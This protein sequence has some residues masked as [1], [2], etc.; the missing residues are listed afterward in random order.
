MAN[1]K[2]GAAR[3]LPIVEDASWDGDAA[4]AGIFRLDEAQWRRGFLFY[5]ADAP[6]N[7]T[8]YSFPFAR[9]SEGRLVAST[10]GI[11]AAAQA[12]GGAR[13]QPGAEFQVPADV[14]A[15]GQAVIDA[16]QNRIEDMRKEDKSAGVI[17][18][19]G[20]VKAVGDGKVEGYLVTFT[21]PDRPDLEGEYF[22]SETNFTRKSGDNIGVFFHHGLDG[23]IK[24]RHIGDGTVTVDNVGIF[25]QG[26]LKLRDAYERAIYR[27]V[28][29]GKMGWSSGTVA[30]LIERDGPYIK[31]W[32]LAEASITPTPA[33]HRNQVVSARAYNR[34]AADGIKALQE[35]LGD[36]HADGSAAVRSGGETDIN[37]NIKL[38]QDEGGRTMS[39]DIN[40]PGQD[41]A[42]GENEDTNNATEGGMAN[43]VERL[44]A[45]DDL[46]K[47]INEVLDVM[48]NTPAMRDVGYFSDAGGRDHPENKSMGD[49]FLAIARDDATRLTE[50]YGSTQKDMGTDSGPLGGYTLPTEF[51]PQIF[52]LDGPMSIVRRYASV[53]P[54]NALKGEFPALDQYLVPGT[55]PQLD[56]GVGDD[57]LAGGITVDRR[58]DNAQFSQSDA[59]LRQVTWDVQGIG[60]SVKASKRL[61]RHS[62][63]S[64]E[65]MLLERF[66]LAIAMKED[67][68]FLRGTNSPLGILASPAAIGVDPETDNS[69]SY[70]D[71]SEMASRF[72]PL[73]GQAK[74]PSILWICHP[75]ILPDITQMEIGSAGAAPLVVDIQ[76]QRLPALQIFG[77]P[78]LTSWHLPQ[79]DNSGAVILADLRAYYI[80]DLQQITVF[81]TEHLYAETGQIGWFFEELVDGK[82]A[83]V[84]TLTAPDPQG[85][86]EMSPFVYHND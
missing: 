31:Q 39:E 28:Q 44:G 19:G 36:D 62:P 33:E 1:W 65:N 45:I 25:V 77:I 22:D 47:T 14:R 50:V 46:S 78:I 23:T 11:R 13:Q 70:K 55:D 76:G 86:F 66:R 24:T 83:V 26:Q 57:P 20:G 73:N 6:E 40:A 41:V 30:N 32:V 56:A 61:V 53:I 42:Q 48:R 71:A 64:I 35:A 15:R 7:K 12:L 68:Y 4:K 2:V 37:I 58:A 34:F 9:A 69:F 27:L 49:W 51:R 82:P 81:A 84:S 16:Y 67:Y 43:I 17:A 54:V 8:S 52:S 3:D 85:S 21:G 80:F 10:A 74:S 5:D 59:L 72:F 63:I 29:D 60:G 18:I 38:T 79:A 75:S